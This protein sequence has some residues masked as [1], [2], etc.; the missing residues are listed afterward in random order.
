MNKIATPKDLVAELNRVLAYAGESNPSR[1]K[2]AEQL[3]EL[4]GAV[5]EGAGGHDQATCERFLDT[6]A[7]ELFQGKAATNLEQVAHFGD[8]PEASRFAKDM[9][10]RVRALSQEIS[11]FLHKMHSKTW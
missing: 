7:N 11:E 6:A 1:V 8:H 4:A 3:T 5:V 10:H 2:I 9:V